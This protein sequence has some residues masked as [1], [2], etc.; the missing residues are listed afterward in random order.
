MDRNERQVFRHDRGDH[1]DADEQHGQDA[2]RHEPVQHALQQR[3][4]SVDANHGLAPV[5]V[6]G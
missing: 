3:E 4:A 2:D 6:R 1:A 5:A